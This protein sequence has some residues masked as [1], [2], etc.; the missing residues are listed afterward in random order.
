MPAANEI[1]RTLE[2]ELTALSKTSGRV[3]RILLTKPGSEDV[4]AAAGKSTAKKTNVSV[5]PTWI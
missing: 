4:G 2:R 3:T 5:R 1:R